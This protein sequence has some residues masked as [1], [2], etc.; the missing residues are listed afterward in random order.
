MADIFLKGLT[1]FSLLLLVG[2][3]LALVAT[4]LPGVLER[5]DPGWGE[6]AAG[7]KRE[8]FQTSETAVQPLPMRESP[9]SRLAAPQAEPSLA[10]AIALAL[11]LH[12]EEGQRIAAPSGRPPGANPWALAGRWQAMQGRL[13]G[14]KR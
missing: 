8:P 2:S 5:L 10:A 13:Q 9:A 4:L 14:R 3:L 12:L 7:L 11:T 6:G 1:G